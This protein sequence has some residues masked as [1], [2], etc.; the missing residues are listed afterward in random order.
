MH[1]GQGELKEEA[2]LYFISFFK[3]LSI[4]TTFEQVKVIGPFSRL[5]NDEEARSLHGKF[6]LNELK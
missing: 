3:A 1:T 2:I 4:P 5:F 6:H